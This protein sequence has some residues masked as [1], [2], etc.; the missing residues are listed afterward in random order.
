MGTALDDFRKQLTR[1]GSPASKSDRWSLVD[2]NII[3]ELHIFQITII[4]FT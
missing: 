1:E 4:K 2:K 3:K